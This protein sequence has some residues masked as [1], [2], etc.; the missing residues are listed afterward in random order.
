[1]S[2][3]EMILVFVL[4]PNNFIILYACSLSC[5]E[6]MKKEKKIN[7]PRGQLLLAGRNAGDWMIWTVTATWMKRRVRMNSRS[8]MGAWSV[9]RSH[10]LGRGLNRASSQTWP[11]WGFCPACRWSVFRVLKTD[12]T[13]LILALPRLKRSFMGLWGYK[14]SDTTKQLN[15]NYLFIFWPSHVVCGILVPWPRIEAM[16]LALVPSQMWEMGRYK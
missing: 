15:N 6:R 13:M 10:S 3:T 16:Q 5:G 2:H 4:T 14:E 7:D 9:G 12:P 11:W 1:M 8:V